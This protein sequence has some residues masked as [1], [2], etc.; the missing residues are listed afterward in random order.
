[1]GVSNARAVGVAADRVGAPP[2]ELAHVTA[3]WLDVQGAEHAGFRGV[4]LNRDDDPEEP[5]GSDPSPPS[6]RSPTNCS[7]DPAGDRSA[8]RVGDP[9]PIRVDAT[10]GDTRSPVIHVTLRKPLIVWHLGV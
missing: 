6:T 5:F 4:W 2:D 1:V 8:R 10:P 9:S 3:L 7:G